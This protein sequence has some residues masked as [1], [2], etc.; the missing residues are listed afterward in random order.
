MLYA[1]TNRRPNPHWYPEISGIS[2]GAKMSDF[3]PLCGGGHLA[4]GRWGILYLYLKIP[5]G[6]SRHGGQVGWALMVLPCWLPQHF[7]VQ[8]TFYNLGIQMPFFYFKNA[9]LLIT[10]QPLYV[11]TI[12]EKFSFRTYRYSRHLFVQFDTAVKI[13]GKFFARLWPSVNFFG[14]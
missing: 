14:F 3:R 10:Q 1:L 4:V 2:W 11:C 12:L 13:L 8:C 9:L 5:V 6:G 7:S